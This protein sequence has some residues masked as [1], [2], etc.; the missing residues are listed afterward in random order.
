VPKNPDG[1]YRDNYGG[2]G[3]DEFGNHFVRRGGGV[4]LDPDERL[5]FVRS[6]L[7]Q[8]IACPNPEEPLCATDY[9]R[10]YH[11]DANTWVLRPEGAAQASY[12]VWVSGAY[13]F[14]GHRPVPFEITVTRAQ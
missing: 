14:V 10:V 3:T 2:C 1:T 6:P 11:P 5:S 12:R 13:L 8:A 7:D 9:I 4:S